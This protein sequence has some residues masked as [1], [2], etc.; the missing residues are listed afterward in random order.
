MGCRFCAST[1]NGLKRNLS[2][3]EMLGQIYLVEKEENVRISHVV[4]MGCGEPFDNYDN[5]VRFLRLVN[6]EKGKNLSLR[7]ITVSTCGLLKGIRSLAK[8][9]LPVTLAI[10]L[11]APNQ[12]IREKLMPVAKSVNYEELISAAGCY[13]KDTGRRVSFEYSLVH[14]LNASTQDAAE[15]AGHLKGL[16]CHVNL[17]PVNPV[18]ERSFERPSKQEVENFAKTLENYGIPVSIRR[19]MGTEIDA[20]CGQLR[21]KRE[22]TL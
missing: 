13:A 16:L 6:A 12:E 10:S 3:G 2:A 9:N 1:I 20:A 8:E 18:R 11:H 22:G 14:G 19:E 17:I 21:A 4:I 7:N 5:V 15:L